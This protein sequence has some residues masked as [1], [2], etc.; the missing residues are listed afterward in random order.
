MTSPGLTP[1]PKMSS[2]LLRLGLWVL[3]LVLAAYVIHESY[4]E[5]TIAEMIPMA[6]LQKVLVLGGLLVAAG[7][8]VKIFEKG[9]KVISK[10]HCRVCRI[11]IP[12]GAI[13]CRAHLRTILYEEDEKTHHTRTRKT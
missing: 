10:N 12:S 7:I 4:E 2:T 6:A 9:T 13:Y 1:V 5:S 11:V 3:V 8:L